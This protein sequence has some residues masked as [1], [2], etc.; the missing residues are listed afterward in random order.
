MSQVDKLHE[1][2]TLSSTKSAS[3]TIPKNQNH[4]HTAGQ[5]Q[6]SAFYKDSPRRQLIDSMNMIVNEASCAVD[7]EIGP[8]IQT[9]S[10][11]NAL[12]LFVREGYVSTSNTKHMDMLMFKVIP[13]LQ[14][15]TDSIQ[16]SDMIYYLSALYLVTRLPSIPE[17]SFDIQPIINRYTLPNLLTLAQKTVQL[18]FNYVANSLNR[19]HTQVE[20]TERSFMPE[21]NGNAKSLSESYWSKLSLSPDNVYKRVSAWTDHRNRVREDTRQK[22]ESERAVEL[23]FIPSIN[24]RLLKQE[25]KQIDKTNTQF[26][27]TNTPNARKRIEDAAAARLYDQGMARH[28]RIQKM[29]IDHMNDKM[30]QEMD[31]CTFSPQIRELKQRVINGSGL[32]SSTN[33]HRRSIASAISRMRQS[34]MFDTPK[35]VVKHGSRKQSQ[36]LMKTLD[37]VVSPSP[38]FSASRSIRSVTP[39]A[40]HDTTNKSTKKFISSS[41]SLIQERSVSA[42]SILTEETYSYRNPKSSRPSGRYPRSTSGNFRPS[43]CDSFNTRLSR[44]EAGFRSIRSMSRSF[45]PIHPTKDIINECINPSKSE[46]LAGLTAISTPLRSKDNPARIASF[47][48]Y[49]AEPDSQ[50]SPPSTLTTQEVRSIFLQKAFSEAQSHSPNPDKEQKLL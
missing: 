13:Q 17:G 18:R 41:P 49:K 29:H 2:A 12:N 42:A 31:Q 27:N 33:S 11:E 47:K 25:E 15:E 8:D 20:D 28:T 10:V 36:S 22:A 30:K 34:H 24:K 26:N 5:S 19:T 7:K 16:R 48:N 1:A 21:I 50:K 44:D 46:Q 37:L 9:L 35:N 23:T 38:P 32:V 43:T 6:Q 40:P 45:S 14:D 4:K 39:R 3:K